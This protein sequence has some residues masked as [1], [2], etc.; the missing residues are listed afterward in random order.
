MSCIHFTDP[1]VDGWFMMESP[2]PSLI[3]TIAYIVLVEYALP[4]YME[5]REAYSLRKTMIVYNFAMV[6]LSGYIFF[7]VRNFVSSNL[8]I[9]FILSFSCF[10]FRNRS[11]GIR[12]PFA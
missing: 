3:L 4:K 11:S 1:R 9:S 2:W 12:Y 7:E 6:A 5:H 8:K 10:G